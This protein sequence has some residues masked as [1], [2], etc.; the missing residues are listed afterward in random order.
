MTT[1][2]IIIPVFNEAEGLGRFCARLCQCA[3]DWKHTGGIED[4]EIIFVDDGSTDSSRR[5]LGGLK[6]VRLIAQGR[7]GY[8]AAIQNGFRHARGEI[9]AF[10]D[11][12][13]TYPPEEFPALLEEL[14]VKN[15]DLIVGSRFLRSNKAMPGHRSLGNRAM[16]C[17]FRRMSK[18]VVTDV[19]SGMR[20]LTRSCAGR[21]RF[22][23]DQLNF[24]S[25]MTAECIF[26]GMAYGEVPITYGERTGISKLHPVKDSLLILQTV[27]RVSELCRRK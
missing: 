14:R 21:F 9:L 4:P 25:A 20:V 15:A 12:D 11:A 7:R 26:S 1:L 13:N 6:K 23:P 2:S 24:S 16:A 5:I 17:L 3:D 19:T 10:I 27:L 8:G 22:L 18:A